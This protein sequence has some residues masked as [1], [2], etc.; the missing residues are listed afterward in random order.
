MK[1]EF[2]ARNDFQPKDTCIPSATPVTVSNL[3]GLLGIGREKTPVTLQTSEFRWHKARARAAV[4]GAH[5][6]LGGDTAFHGNDRYDNDEGPDCVQV[7]EQAF[8][9]AG[10]G[11]ALKE[12]VGDSGRQHGDQCGTPSWIQPRETVI[13]FLEKNIHQNFLYCYVKTDFVNTSS[14]YIVYHF[15]HELT[16]ASVIL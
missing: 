8:K 3:Q 10:L 16:M 2:L 13:I 11:M 1:L 7:Y 9:W 5:S 6:T 15:H 4:P 14:K 12:E